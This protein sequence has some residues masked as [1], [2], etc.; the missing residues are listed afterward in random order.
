M[1]DAIKQAKPEELNDILLAVLDRYREVYPDWELT[2][3]SLEKAVD[4][5]EQ[6]DRMIALI[7]K[8][9]EKE[10]SLPHLCCIF[11]KFFIRTICCGCLIWKQV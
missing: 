4:K 1:I 6:L 7:E 10:G 5:N 11:Y 8:M 2:T 3:I 9:K